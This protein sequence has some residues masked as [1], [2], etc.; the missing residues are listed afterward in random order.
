MEMTSRCKSTGHFFKRVC[1][2]FIA[3]LRAVMK[4]KQ[5]QVS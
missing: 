3:P 2:S 1:L 5:F 4:D